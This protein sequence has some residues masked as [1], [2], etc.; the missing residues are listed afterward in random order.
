MVAANSG[1]A[2][3]RFEDF[4]AKEI[5]PKNRELFDRF[6][7]YYCSLDRSEQSQIR[8][9]SWVLRYLIYLR[10]HGDK[11][12]IETTQADVAVYEEEELYMCTPTTVNTSRG[13]IRRFGKFIEENLFEEYP[14]YEF[15][16]EGFNSKVRQYADKKV[17][18]SQRKLDYLLEE[19]TNREEYE[20]ACFLAICA[21]SNFTH[22]EVREI[23]TDFFTYFNLQLNN[24]MWAYET[25]VMET[26]SSMKIHNVGKRRFC[27]CKAQPYITR[28]IEQR[29]KRN[30]LSEYLFPR[31][32]TDVYCKYPKPT[33]R[34]LYGK[35]NRL[36]P[37]DEPINDANLF[38]YELREMIVDEIPEAVIKVLYG[39]STAYTESFKKE[40]D[41]KYVNQKRKEE[42]SSER[43]S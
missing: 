11:L 42:K 34:A 17:L 27:L 4:R 22:D 12:F 20:A 38:E 6:Y 9:G 41:Y 39:K 13:A 7:D 30:V 31:N 43:I 25:M 3:K 16:L 29:G 35:V 37:R 15:H 21:Y 32:T 1:W 33:M 14:D 40:I 5:N 10:S 18:F 19:L 26:M 8:N 24:Y 36:L 2:K 28:W 23:R